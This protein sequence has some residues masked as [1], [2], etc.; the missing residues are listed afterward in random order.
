MDLD[1]LRYSKLPV[2]LLHYA[3]NSHAPLFHEVCLCCV[4]VRHAAHLAR[5]TVLQSTHL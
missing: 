2:R 3:V 5:R 1:I 4:M